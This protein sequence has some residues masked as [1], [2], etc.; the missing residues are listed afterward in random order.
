MTAADHSD[1]AVT[2]ALSAVY[3]DARG[4]AERECHCWLTLVL[5]HVAWGAAADE[6]Q[7]QTI[8]TTAVDVE[9]NAVTFVN[10]TATTIEAK[11]GQ[12]HSSVTASQ[13]LPNIQVVAAQP[14]RGNRQGGRS[15]GGV[16]DYDGWDI[17]GQLLYKTTT[18]AGETSVREDASVTIVP[19]DTT[20]SVQQGCG[21][22]LL[23][24]DDVDDDDDDDDDDDFQWTRHSFADL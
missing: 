13:R 4:S 17:S 21:T 19:A 1:D 9:R 24:T 14:S 6:P 5:T 12:L 10:V 23:H 2:S 15:D 8:V 3:G 11:D 16:G 18:A 22:V 20:A 7:L